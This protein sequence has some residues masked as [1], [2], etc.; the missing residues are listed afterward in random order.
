MFISG[1]YVYPFGIFDRNYL[2][3]P[4]SQTLPYLLNSS[5]IKTTNI[6]TLDKSSN[7]FSILAFISSII[8][9]LI[10]KR[11]FRF[12]EN[13]IR[14]LIHPYGF[15]VDL[16]D[17]RIISTLNSTI[18]GVFTSLQMANF[19]GAYLFFYHDNLRTQEYLVTISTMLKMRVSYLSFTQEPW[20]IVL[21]LL[22][23]FY[24]IHLI[25]AMLLKFASF[26]QRVHIRFRQGLA[27]SNWSGS[28]AVFFIP[29]S[30]FG[31]YLFE[32][33]VLSNILWPIFIFFFIWFNFRLANG[34]R[35]LFILRPLKIIIIMILTYMV[36]IVTLLVY[37]DIPIEVYEYF[38]LLGN[39]DGLFS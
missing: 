15:F 31:Y 38:K 24:M 34:I 29:L 35:V 27:V 28:H 25:V 5:T 6:I 22:V 4:F 7:F 9:L 39:T 21:I 2:P 23:L 3:R 11:N 8:F 32:Q 13:L 18:L 12:R 1:E 14:S 20:Q 19:A 30:M 17:R 10:Y 37:T 16:R 36:I 33:N 26:I